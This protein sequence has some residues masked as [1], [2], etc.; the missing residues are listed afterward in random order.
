MSL[1][2]PKP[3]PT[4]NRIDRKR[5]RERDLAAAR[6]AVWERD[7][8]KCRSCGR[9]VVRNSGGAGLRGHVHHVV[10]RS[11]SKELRSEI[12]NL[13]LLCEL[14]H[15]AVHTYRLIITQGPRG[16]YHFERQP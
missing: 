1:A 3:E 14:C 15:S 12:T 9:G 16:G 4:A 10:K 5:Q 8:R 11:Q 2:F 13:L 7:N 6:A